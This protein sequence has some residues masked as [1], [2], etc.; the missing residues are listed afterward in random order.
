MKSRS[1]LTILSLIAVLLF[2]FTDSHAAGPWEEIVSIKSGNVY[3][4]V[5]LHKR[6][7]KKKV[8]KGD[9]I[10]QFKLKYRL[11]EGK[12]EV[13]LDKEL[14]VFC[15]TREAFATSTKLIKD[16]TGTI[17]RGYQDRQRTKLTGKDY[18]DF[19]NV[20]DLLCAR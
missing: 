1:I 9:K 6:S 14:E 5:D 11:N 8:V 15:S 20:M 17:P 2:P 18:E 13:E 10:L 16:E 4:R 12:G 3:G 7:F 19:R